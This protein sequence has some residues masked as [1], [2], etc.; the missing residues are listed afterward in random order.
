MAFKVMPDLFRCVLLA[1]LVSQKF[2]YYVVDITVFV[3][4]EIFC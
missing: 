2:V 3:P 1:C 4:M